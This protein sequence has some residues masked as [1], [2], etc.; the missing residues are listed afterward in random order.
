MTAVLERLLI[1]RVFHR[2]ALGGPLSERERALG[3]TWRQHHPGWELRLWTEADL[4]PLANQALF[5]AA[6]AGQ[7]DDIAKYELLLAHGGVFI[8]TDMECLRSI[9]PLLD[10]VEVFCARED[11]FRL[12][13]G[14]LG[15]AAGS[16]LIEAVVAALPN[17]VGWRPGRPRDEQTGAEL[18]TRI[19]AEQDALGRVTPAVFGPELFYPY[20]WTEPPRAGATF[21]SAYA[22][23]HWLSAFPSD[24]APAASVPPPSVVAAEAAVDRILVT[25]DPDLVESA[26]VVLAGAMELAMAT[27][28]ME[29]GLVVKGVP[30]VTEAVGDAMAG[31]MQQLAGGRDMPEVVVY[32]EPEGSSLSASVRLAM[33]D[34]PATNARALLSRS[35]AAAPP[36]A[37][38]E[39]PAP[40]GGMRGTYIGN[41]RMLVDVVYGAMLVVPSDDY[42]L[43]PSLVTWGAIEPPLTKFLAGEIKAGQTF[44][45]V[46]AN[47]GYFTVLATQRVGAAGRVIAFEANPT[48][49][50][51]LRDNLAVNWLTEHNVEVRN[52]AAYSE[53]GTIAFNASARWVGD[54]SIRHRPENAHR[55]DEITRLNIPAVRL[56]DALADAGTIDILK[57]DIEGGEY[58]AFLGMQNLIRRR[59]IRRIVFEWNAVMLGEERDR[60]ADFLRGI[61]GRLSVL[62]AQA[63]PTPVAV[64]D[65]ERVAFYPFAIIDL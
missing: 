12:A 58:H 22:V 33:S 50:G 54:S 64:S 20:H 43:M 2:L 46:G 23:C 31:L 27:P 10:G 34:D 52:Q 6:P 55:L 47:I 45:D 65:L 17:S 59:R 35:V 21:P 42:S 57:I 48:T 3:E 19:V 39:K 30:E 5:D 8:G 40:H 4:P 18:L 13:D 11:G 32:S 61:D 63:R 24:I 60:F 51:I 26:A 25:V 36:A 28:G 53:N 41:N 38:V 14:V 37:P 44:V 9:E 15:A 1:P 7:R 16:P 49:A 62:D 29:L 56:D